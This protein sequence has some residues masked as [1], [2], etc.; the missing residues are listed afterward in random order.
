MD[1]NTVLSVYKQRK[2]PIYQKTLV[3]SVFF[4]T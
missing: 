3:K 1:E 2:R 4:I